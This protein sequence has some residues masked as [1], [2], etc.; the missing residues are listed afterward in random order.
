MSTAQNPIILKRPPAH[1]YQLLKQRIRRLRVI[2]RTIAL[3]ISIATFIPITLTLH[4][5]LTTQNIFKTITNA[6]GEVVTRT[7]WANDSKVWPTWMYFAI[8][9]VTVVLHIGIMV[10]YMC[11]VGKANKV[12]IIASV[13]TWTVLVG[14]LVVWCVAAS[15]YRTEKD[16][17]GK[18]NDLWGW[19]C[20]PA[21]RA[22]QKDF[23]E[24]DFDRFCTVQVS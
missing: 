6:Q 22:I 24:V 23:G 12:S 20:S 15:L 1:Q 7:A 18:S 4:K 5:F 16:K 9:A 11:G 17:D 8:A 19:T 3:L 13:F 14:N 21:A 10:G 2:S